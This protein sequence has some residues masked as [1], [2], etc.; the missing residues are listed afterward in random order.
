MRPATF[1]QNQFFQMENT[2]EKPTEKVDF[3]TWSM[4]LINLIAEYHNIP[5]CQVR[6]RTDVAKAW[7]DQGMSPYHAFRESDLED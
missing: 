1:H 7:Y 2:V 6:L 4:S 5:A 3:A